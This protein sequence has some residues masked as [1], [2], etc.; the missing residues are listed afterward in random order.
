MLLSSSIWAFVFSD[1]N[2]IL[3]LLKTFND[4]SAFVGSKAKQKILKMRDDILLNVAATSQNNTS[5]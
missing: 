2:L 1:L 5:S 3:L 4:I